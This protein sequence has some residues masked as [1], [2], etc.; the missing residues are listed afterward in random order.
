[1]S[2]GSARTFLLTGASHCF[3]PP[4]AKAVSINVTIAR[5]GGTGY[6]S[7]FPSGVATPPI[8]AT[9]TFK[10][11]DIVSNAAI[12][13]LGTDGGATALVVGAGADLIIDMNGYFGGAPLQTLTWRGAWSSTASYGVGDLVSYAGSSWVSRSPSNQGITPSSGSSAWNLVA[14]KGESGPQGPAGPQGPSGPQGPADVSPW[15]LSSGVLTYGGS[16][17]LGGGNVLV[18]AER[19][20]VSRGGAKVITGSA[21]GTFKFVAGGSNYDIA[22]FLDSANA[23]KVV[24]DHAGGIKFTNQK[25]CSI[26]VGN[27]WRDNLLVPSSWTAATCNRLRSTLGASG[28]QLGCIFENDF[29]YGPVGSGIPTPNCGW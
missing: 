14:Q 18:D 13:P 24:I 10:G 15:Q 21:G 9:L 12:V 8:V 2:S 1:M 4:A 19:G 28:Y 17:G 11:G 16:I 5:T 20:L 6:L 25:I 23:Q 3:I 27:V 7:L 29:S 22:Q 26:F